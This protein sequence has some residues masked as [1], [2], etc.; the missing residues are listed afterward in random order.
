MEPVT[1]HESGSSAQ[2]L[3]GF[4]LIAVGFI[5]VTLMVYGLT[6]VSANWMPMAMG[7]LLAYL[8]V[9]IL[10]LWLASSS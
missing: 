5:A 10:A 6:G 4:S 8:I 7:G 3:L 2:A 9:W 1:Q